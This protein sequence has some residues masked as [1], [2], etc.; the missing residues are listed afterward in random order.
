[1]DVT[2]AALFPR[3]QHTVIEVKVMSMST[4]ARPRAVARR[5]I[6]AD[7]SAAASPLDNSTS[8]TCRHR[9]S[10]SSTFSSDGNSGP[11]GRNSSTVVGP[12]RSMSWASRRRALRSHWSN[13]IIRTPQPFTA[14]LGTSCASRGLPARGMRSRAARSRPCGMTALPRCSPDTHGQPRVQRL[15]GVDCA[16]KHSSRRGKHQNLAPDVDGHPVV[17]QPGV[18]G[19]RRSGQPRSS[20]TAASSPMWFAL[21]RSPVWPP[22]CPLARFA[23]C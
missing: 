23:S 11:T 15:A 1:M 22:R 7:V 2:G 16:V 6:V 21:G 20:C 9:S 5:I 14:I 8:P 13:L 3:W 4:V 10:T 19:P 18:P 12:L 17:R